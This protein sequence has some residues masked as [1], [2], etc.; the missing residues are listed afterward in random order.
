MDPKV[1]NLCELKKRLKKLTKLNH[2]FQQVI[3]GHLQSD[4]IIPLR[5]DSVP[6]EGYDC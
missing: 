2:L 4:H 3:L 6:G 1:M 5:T